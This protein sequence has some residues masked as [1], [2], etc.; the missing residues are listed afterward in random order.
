MRA[1][2]NFAKVEIAAKSPDFGRLQGLLCA[3]SIAWVGIWMPCKFL[4]WLWQLWLLVGVWDEIMPMG[5]P[6]ALSA[7]I[8]T[9]FFQNWSKER[10]PR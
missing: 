2:R 9:G 7:G 4:T 6:A 3:V 5:F 1:V 10:S 8:L